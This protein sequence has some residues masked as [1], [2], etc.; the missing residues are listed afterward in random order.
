MLQLVVH[1]GVSNLATCLN[2]EKCATRSGYSRLDE[3]QAIPSCGKGCL[4]SLD[5]NNTEECILTDI[6]LIELSEELNELL[7]D[8]KTIV[9]NNAGRYICEYTY[10]A[11][12]SMDS[13]RTIFVHVPTL[14]VY[15]TQQ[16]SQG[17]ENIIRILVKQ[18]RIASQDTCTVKS[19]IF[20]YSLIKESNK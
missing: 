4:C 20:N 8:V 1:V 18:L 10:Y 14:D 19:I 7:P 15:S 2:L 5:G 12:L 11:S 17:L 13:S 9:S 6:D 16:I 3:K